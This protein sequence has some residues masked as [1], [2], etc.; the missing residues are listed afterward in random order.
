L[1]SERPATTFRNVKF[2]PVKCCFI[3]SSTRK[4]RYFTATKRPVTY[5]MDNSFPSAGKKECSGKN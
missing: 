4:A 5:L 3:K 2:R 1:P